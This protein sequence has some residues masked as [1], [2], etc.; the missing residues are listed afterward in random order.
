MQAVEGKF[1]AGE[2]LAIRRALGISLG[3]AEQERDFERRMQV[4]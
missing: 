4:T 1:S 3:M 2:R